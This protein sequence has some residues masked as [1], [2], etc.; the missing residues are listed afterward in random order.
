MTDD[1]S[2][3]VCAIAV[4]VTIV[5]KM[6]VESYVT[7]LRQSVLT[8]EGTRQKVLAAVQEVQRRRTSAV[9]SRDFMKRRI[10]EAKTRMAELNSEI[11]NLKNEKDDEGEGTGAAEEVGVLP[12]EEVPSEALGED[13]VKEPEAEVEDQVDEELTSADTEE[14]WEDEDEDDGEDDWDD[15]DELDDEDVNVKSR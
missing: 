5:V 4:I 7:K 12:G 10:E 2:I 3:L 1:I 8:L 13:E 11:H 14:G 9:G 6:I 15:E